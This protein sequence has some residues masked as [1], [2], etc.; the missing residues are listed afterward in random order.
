MIVLGKGGREK[1]DSYSP[2]GPRKNKSLGADFEWAIITEVDGEEAFG[3]VTELLNRAMLI[4]LLSCLGVGLMALILAG[5][6]AGPVRSMARHA[7]QVSAGDLTAEFPKLRRS[8]EI[9]ALAKSFRRMVANLREQAKQVRESVGVLSSSVIEISGTVSQ[10]ATGTS[11]TASA[12]TETTSTVSE[13]KEA[14]NAS[15]SMAQSVSTTSRQAVQVSESGAKATEETIERMNLI[16]EQMKSIG[17]TVVMLNEQGAE[18][19]QIIEAV[20][21]LADQSNLL[22][23][24][25]SIEAARAGEQGRGFA[26]VAHEIKSLADQ[27]KQA[28]DQVRT[29]LQ[30]TREWI[31]AVVLATEEGMKA[32]DAGVEQSALAGKSIAALNSSVLQSSEAAGVIETTSNQQAAAVEQVSE[33]MKRIEQAMTENMRSTTQLESAAEKLRSLGHHLEESLSIYKV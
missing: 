12:V 30:D 9:G 17:D 5:S 1:L 4:M 19:D 21:D 26:V 22:A 18:V 11:K 31:S 7:A 23:V 20:Q 33:A 24:N 28:T 10:L 2:V 25:A 6:I 27:S 14:A 13:V 15:N 3:P 16:K 8:D 32:V 29:I